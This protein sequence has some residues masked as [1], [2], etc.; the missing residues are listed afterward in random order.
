MAEVAE[1]PSSPRQRKGKRHS[2]SRGAANSVTINVGDCKYQVVREAARALGWRLVE[3][4]AESGR[5]CNIQWVDVANVLEKMQQIQP[6]QRI[7][8]FPG[9]NN[10]ARKSR[11]AQNLDR[12][13]R[14]F[15]KEY[16]FY[17]RTWVLPAEWSLFRA[18]FDAQGK[19]TRTFIIKPDSGCQ[20]KGIYLTQD[21]ERVSPMETQVAQLYVRRPLLVEGLKFDLRVYVL[22]TSVRPLRVFVFRDGLAR[23]CTEEY[24][25]PAASNVSDRC[26][27]LTNYAVNKASDRFVA[28]TDPER[29]D[30]GS[31]R[32]LK[33]LMHWIAQHHSQD[34]ASALWRK[35]VSA[36]TKT[37][38]SVLPQLRRDYGNIFGPA[39]HEHGAGP[40]PPSQS[41]NDGNTA[42][43]FDAD[44]SP[45]PRPPL[46]EVAP[47][48]TVGGSAGPAPPIEGSRCIEILG[49]DFLIDANLKPWLIEVNHLPSFATDSPL[50]YNI[51][52]RVVSTA[53]AVWRVK[54]TDR[55]SH[56][57]AARRDAQQRLYA[58]RTAE[59]KS[60]PAGKEA[61]E[62]VRL[63]RD[64]EALYRAYAP[65][66]LSKVGALCRKYAG[67]EQKLLQLVR[68]KYCDS[69]GDGAASQ[70]SGPVQGTQDGGAD[71]M[72]QT[73]KILE[74]NSA[75]TSPSHAKWSARQKGPMSAPAAGT[76]P[77]E[78]RP[79]GSSA[80]PTEDQLADEEDA[81][82]AAPAE[83]AREDQGGYVDEVA[84]VAEAGRAGEFGE[85]GGGAGSVEVAAVM[86]AAASTAAASTAVATAV[87]AT[88]RAAEQEEESA[89]GRETTPGPWEEEENEHE[90]ARE[91][92]LL[93]GW[94]QAYPPEAGPKGAV[95]PSH[96]L[97]QQLMRHAF[98]EETKM[99]LRMRGPL[100]KQR[101]LPGG[102]LGEGGGGSGVS[103]GKLPG[104]GFERLQDELGVGPGAYQLPDPWLRGGSTMGKA[105]QRP[106]ERVLPLSG[107]RQQATADRLSKGFSAHRQQSPAA[108][109]GEAQRL[110][111]TLRTAIAH[112][113]EWRMR[114]EEAKSRRVSQAVA[115]KVET[116][117]F[118]DCLGLGLGG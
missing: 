12:M 16:A 108:F 101:S 20:G 94:D 55:Q 54:A 95:G 91:K 49:F 67:R 59:P 93:Q 106:E 72:S 45:P 69:D 114:V 99:I 71:V 3:G 74:S 118:G 64:V 82:E 39:S 38:V 40:R 100:Q 31:K 41:S 70:L 96:R 111:A 107:P 10:I 43:P 85:A 61:A 88:T 32:S 65:H 86:D 117:D 110:P 76:A 109:R 56:E 25:Q 37:L 98:E 9:M 24:L 102:A 113:K 22:L 92:A 115:L 6:W 50:D 53:L 79:G 87:A 63:Q 34:K 80:A 21:A 14:A 7:N 28:N 60:A 103:G 30:V 29:D 15:P 46:P 8:H 78:S 52:R 1:T 26:M 68:A 4:T 90:L 44:A 57:E 19:S 97:V 18:E 62:V 36:C 17:P 51:K 105:P 13:R 58:T 27:H 33:W 104:I 66:K 89:T 112:A 48:V 35:L 2:G 42:A 75:P 77:P 84:D 11:M 116:F 83:P 23:F 73:P 81:A 5:R 47:A